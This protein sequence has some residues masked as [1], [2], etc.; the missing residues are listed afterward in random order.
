MSE[1]DIIENGFLMLKED[2]LTLISYC[3]FIFNEFYEDVS[4]LKCKLKAISSEIQCIVANGFSS[5]EI[6]FGST[7]SPTLEDYADGIDTVDFL[8]KI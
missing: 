5:K 6:K 3:N 4:E 8:L 7:Q 1:F 2:L